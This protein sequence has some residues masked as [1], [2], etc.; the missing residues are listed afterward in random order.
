MKVQLKRVYENMKGMMGECFFTSGTSAVDAS[1][2][3]DSRGD[4]TVEA[5]HHLV[6]THTCGHN[7]AQ[8]KRTTNTHTNRMK[9]TK[10][11]NK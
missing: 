8:T 2:C 11:K 3:C 1:S 4:T 5:S 10:S 7:N 6:T 9:N